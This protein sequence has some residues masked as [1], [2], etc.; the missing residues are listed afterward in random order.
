ML[1]MTETAAESSSFIMMMIYL[2]IFFVVTTYNV[3]IEIAFRARRRIS[4]KSFKYYER[5]YMLEPNYYNIGFLGFVIILSLIFFAVFIGSGVTRLFCITFIP[6]DLVMGLFIYYEL[7]RSKYNNEEIS[8]FDSYYRDLNRIENSKTQLLNKITSVENEF[9]TL[10]SNNMKNFNEFNQ[11]IPNK[12]KEQEFQAYIE[13]RLKEFEENRNELVNY[14]KLVISQFNTA[15]TDYLT[16]G[17]SSFQEI[18][19]FKTIDIQQ[20]FDYVSTMRQMFESYV[21][22]CSKKKL[23]EGALKNSD[24]IIQLFDI[25]LRFNVKFEEDDMRVILNKINDNVSKKDDVALFL[26]EKNLISEEVLHHC[27]V[28]KDWDWCVHENFIFNKN[29]KKIIELYI[30][31]VQANA[32]KC[33]NKMLKSNLMDQSDMLVKVLNAVSISNPCTQ[34]IKFRIIIQTND[35]Q[36]DKEANMYENMAVSIRNYVLANPGDENRA[37][38]IEVCDKNTFY[39]EKERIQDIYTRI[40]QKL[41]EKYAYLN[42]VLICFYEG[43][44]SRDKYI[45]NTKITN[46]Y[47]ENLLTLNNQT[48][49]VFSLLACALIL[50]VDEDDAN[51]DVALDGLKKDQIGRDAINQC[52]TD[53]EIG[54][55]VLKELFNS[56]L[57]KLIPIV[58]RVETKRM[59]L[60]KLRRLINES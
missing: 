49:R 10:S 29:R 24:K 3:Y 27:I 51:V 12:D 2:S 36:F 6:T 4:Y 37:W 57:D 20:M 9:K 32:I 19:E 44:L 18:P 25:A 45:D 43:E 47:L 16:Q 60:D 30:D 22:E 28:D 26:L 48:L 17:L 53:V 11:L 7:T 58:N 38:I 8:S 31:V 35:Q 34:V 52:T 14:N 55:Y 40:S 56:K 15:L 59:S 13:S 54:K 39:E 1:E 50:C 23:R 46:L 41:K 33:C 21:D 42:N 5:M